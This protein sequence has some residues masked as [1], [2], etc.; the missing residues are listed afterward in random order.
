MIPLISQIFLLITLRRNLRAGIHRIEQIQRRKLAS[1]LKHSY[2]NVPFYNRKFKAAGIEPSKIKSPADLSRIPFTTKSE[3]QAGRQDDIV[4]QGINLKKCIKRTTS[5][6]TGN[7]LAIYVSPKACAY[8]SLIWYRTE[9]ENGLK[10]SD[11]M[12]MLRNPRDFPRKESLLRRLGIL[13]RKYISTFNA[14]ELQVSLLKKFKP[15]VIR[16][17]PSSLEILAIECEKD[18]AEMNPRLLFVGAELLDEKTKT[19]IEKRY[20]AE[21]FDNYGSEEFSLMAWECRKHSGYHINSDN[22]LL[23]LVDNGGGSETVSPGERGEIVVTSLNNYAMPLIRYRIGDLGVFSDEPCSCGV[24]LPLMKVVEGRKDDFLL[25][26][27]GRLVGPAAR[28]IFDTSLVDIKGM[29]QYRVIQEKRDKLTIQ[30]LVNE[31]FKA[32]EKLFEEAEQ[33]LEGFFGKGMQFEFQPTGEFQKD[34][35]GKRRKFISRIP[36]MR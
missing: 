36:T 10:I 8:D 1:I 7:P 5:G 14:A 12:A 33:K 2:L 13:R 9:F 28:Q 16:S 11:K 17:T 18:L 26:L 21:V 3:I 22:V 32:D 6:S 25:T 30:L 20:R 34:S 29:V 15:D 23:E 35:S 24:S 4:A 31:L 27:D 19:L